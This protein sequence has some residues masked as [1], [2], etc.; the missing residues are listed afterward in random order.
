MLAHVKHKSKNK[1]EFTNLWVSVM[2]F[3]GRH[4]SAVC[5]VDLQFSDSRLSTGGLIPD[6]FI[7][8]PSSQAII[9]AFGQF[10]RWFNPWL[11]RSG[12]L[13]EKRTMMRAVSSISASGRASLNLHKNYFSEVPHRRIGVCSSCRVNKTLQKS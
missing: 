4:S 3:K 9:R 13:N 10:N 5:R 7:H 8:I 2:A 1:A 11:S 6:V 12:L